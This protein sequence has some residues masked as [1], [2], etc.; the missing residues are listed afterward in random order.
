M[1]IRVLLVEDNPIDLRLL[2]ADFRKF[3]SAE[4]DLTAVHSLSEAVR[5]LQENRIDVILLDLFLE[6][7]TGMDTL[8]HVREVA[9]HV[10]CV[11]LTG[12]DD[13]GQA[14]QALKH[15]AQD[16]LIKGKVDSHAL[17]RAIRY[18]IERKQA[19]RARSI[20][21]ERLYHGHKLEA[22]GTLASGVAHN[23]NN[24]LMVILGHCNLMREG[25]IDSGG[26]RHLESIKKAA[27]R[28]ALLTRQL[29]IF[30]R[31]QPAESTIIDLNA[32]VSGLE[33]LL[34]SML[35]RAIE[36]ELKLTT[37][38][39]F[40]EADPHQIGEILLNLAKNAREAMPLGGRLTIQTGNDTK[41]GQALLKVTD[42]GKGMPPEIREHIFEPFFTTKGLAVASGLGLSTV[43]AIVKQHDGNIHVSSEPGRGTEFTIAFPI[44]NTVKHSAEVEPLPAVLV[45][46]DDQKVRELCLK[47]LGETARFLVLKANDWKEVTEVIGSYGGPIDL[48]IADAV[49]PGFIR[50]HLV[51]HLVTE[52]PQTKIIYIWRSFARSMAGK[53]NLPVG[54][55]LVQKELTGEIL[56]EHVRG[57][58]NAAEPT[59]VEPCMT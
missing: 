41:S 52:H 49:T 15:G 43:Y 25:V 27:D 48:L 11:V 16:Y 24:A 31:K 6:E 53:S 40:I 5:I 3:G 10:P 45:V 12:L 46:A 44:F 59:F 21:E 26:R 18:A 34:E 30:S 8:F 29:L 13:E 14:L 35:D 2:S 7:T 39:A 22:V 37:K 58:L 38:A 51:R 9:P 55:H 4:F 19:E 42:N 47:A 23:F 20:L 56:S 17:F 57:A 32:T 36:L 54:V 33:L 50:P 1:S 28:A